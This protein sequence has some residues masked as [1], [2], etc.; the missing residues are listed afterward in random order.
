M[1]AFGPRSI[2]GLFFG[3]HEKDFLLKNIKFGELVCPQF[4][5]VMPLDTRHHPQ[6]Y[7]EYPI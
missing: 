4:I 3:V 1:N 2:L 5:E 6:T 7:A